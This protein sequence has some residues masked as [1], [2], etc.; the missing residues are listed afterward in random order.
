M[1]G[2]AVDGVEETR[3]GNTFFLV[4]FT[5]IVGFFDRFGEVCNFEAVVGGGSARC[6]LRVRRRGLFVGIGADQTSRV[7]VFE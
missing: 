1:G 3:E 6:G 5:G 7:N 4:F 2:D